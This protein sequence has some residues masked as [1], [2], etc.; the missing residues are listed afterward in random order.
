MIHFKLTDVMAQCE[1][2]ESNVCTRF[3]Q[4]ERNGET[5]TEE[6]PLSK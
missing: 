6:D 2:V 1:I 5:T 3:S 4:M